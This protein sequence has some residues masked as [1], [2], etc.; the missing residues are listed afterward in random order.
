MTST[1]TRRPIS[2]EPQPPPAGGSVPGPACAPGCPVPRHGH[3]DDR[4]DPRPGGRPAAGAGR[5]RGGGAGRGRGGGAGRGRGGGEARGR[6]GGAARGRGGGAAHGRGDGA[7]PGSARRRA[8]ARAHGSVDPPRRGPL[9]D[10]PSQ[11]GPPAGGAGLDGRQAGSRGRGAGGG[12][13]RRLSPDSWPSGPSGRNRPGQPDFVPDDAAPVLDADPAEIDLRHPPVHPRIAGR[14]KEVLSDERL[15]R[16]RYR[17]AGRCVAVLLS[18][19][20]AVGFSPLFDMDHLLVEGVEG[21]PASEVSEATAWRGVR[22]VVRRGCLGRAQQGRRSPVG[23]PCIRERR[24]AR[25]RRSAGH[26]AAARRQRGDRRCRA[27]RPWQRAPGRS[28]HTTTWRRWFPSPV[29]FRCC[30]W[31]RTGTADRSR[32]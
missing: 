15:R 27:R 20:A 3:R 11:A 9:Q 31:R 16:R 8:R 12:G 13:R 14:R 29:G 21:D 19:T 18:A 1:G 25:S 28:S 26:A 17:I 7:S 23:V 6:G 10:T 4:P 2:L 24:M 5:G 32:R 30:G 22:S